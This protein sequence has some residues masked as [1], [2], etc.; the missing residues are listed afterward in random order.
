MPYGENRM[1]DDYEDYDAL[2]LAALVRDGHV[3][4]LEVLEAAI[5]RAE[6]RNPAINAIV[7]TMFEA[8]RETANDPP[9][10]PLA[11]VPFLVK[12]LNYVKGVRCTM[13]SRFFADFVPDHDAEIVKRHRAAGLVI[14]GKTNTPEVGLAATTEGAMLG[15]CRNPWDTG[16]T[17]GGSSGGAASA[18][19]ANIL[20]AAHATDGG[21]SIRIP[22]SCCGLVG[23]KP[24]RGRTP[25]GPDVGE[26]WGGM[27]TGHVVT[28]TVRDSAAFLDATHGPAA[29]DPYHAPY[30]AGSFLE[31]L[32]AAPG[33][34]KIALNLTPLSGG[35]VAQQN[36]TAATNAA[37]LCED[38]GHRVE[39]ATP[40]V[41]EDF[42]LA[43]GAIVAAN[44]ANTISS[45]ALILGREPTLDDIEHATMD[46]VENGKTAPAHR[47]PWA[48]S[49]I[50]RTGRALAE[51]HANYDILLTPTLLQP[52]VPIG[53]LNPNTE[54]LATYYARFIDFWGFTNL[55]NAT[56]QPAISLPLHW[57]ED[58]LPV[59]VQFAAA[60]GEEMLLL[61]LAAQ[62]ETAAPWSTRRP[63]VDEIV[64]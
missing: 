21:G 13:G 34:L 17:P 56:G 55:Q 26:G 42:G 30:S 41:G 37:K 43:T 44:V 62:L 54:D 40:S 10:G 23:L 36:V 12:D 50:H 51:F 45:R 6:R 22:A 32:D 52:P 63:P 29:G 64:A 3:T 39:E 15:P 2:G 1:F 4:A 18:V 57:T 7:T 49:V 27:S 53:W 16:R 33:P 60:Q 20:P 24:T 58:G 11:G 25:L 61:R 9:Q 19:A 47:Y 35:T 46:S 38:L 8:A 28:R 48:M 31:S 5:E 14:F 59:G